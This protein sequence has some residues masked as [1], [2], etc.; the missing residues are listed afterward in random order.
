MNDQRL[1]FMVSYDGRT[2]EKRHG[3]PLPEHLELTHLD[4]HAGRSSQ[5]TLLGVDHATVESLYLS[6]ALLWRLNESTYGF[7]GSVY[8]WGIEEREEKN[9]AATYNT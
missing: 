6:P 3:K 8:L 1:S 5:S 7:T 4:I 2:G 9:R